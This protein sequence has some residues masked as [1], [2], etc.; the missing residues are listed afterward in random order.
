MLNSISGYQN[1]LPYRNIEQNDNGQVDKKNTISTKVDVLVNKYKEDEKFAKAVNITASV[2]C[3]AGLA[4]GVSRLVNRFFNKRL[5]DK[6]LLNNENKLKSL[7]EDTTL[8]TNVED[9][10]ILMNKA[11]NN[12]FSNDE[13]SIVN[14]IK[15]QDGKWVAKNGK[16]K[17][18]A[19]KFAQFMNARNIENIDDLSYGDKVIFANDWISQIRAK[20][21][22]YGALKYGESITK[23]G[24]NISFNNLPEGLKTDLKIKERNLYKPIHKLDSSK[25]SKEI[26]K[27]FDNNRF[28][29]YSYMLD[30]GSYLESKMVNASKDNI[31]SLIYDKNILNIL[32]LKNNMQ[33]S[34]N[35]Q[36][37]GM[38]NAV[39]ISLIGNLFNKKGK[40]SSENLFD[41]VKNQ[42][43]WNSSYNGFFN[44]DKKIDQIYKLTK[45]YNKLV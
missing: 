11:I 7:L 13:N 36:L 33:E 2:V 27:G 5:I 15:I 40:I 39:K 30:P 29:K 41:L 10:K 32:N 1:T 16:T 35:I 23:S 22:L 26:E 8:S 25:V 28:S 34:I 21:D 38:K 14:S 6:K 44:Q 12:L 31:E 24:N 37:P 43:Y 20:R 17:G 45:E 4:L 3:L 18:R 9:N 19:F 42:L